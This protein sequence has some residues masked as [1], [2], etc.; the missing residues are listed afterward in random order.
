MAK[1]SAHGCHHIPSDLGKINPGK[2]GQNVHFCAYFVR[3]MS[4]RACDSDSPFFSA[5]CFLNC[6]FFCMLGS[7]LCVGEAWGVRVE[8]RGKKSHDVRFFSH[9]FT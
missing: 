3:A 4:V 9:A 6:E 1:H 5:L 2:L 8:K 7:A